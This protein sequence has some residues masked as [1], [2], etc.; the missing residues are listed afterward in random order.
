[1]RAWFD[2]NFKLLWALKLLMFFYAFFAKLSEIY[3]KR[4]FHYW[5]F[6]NIYLKICFWFFWI[7]DT[8]RIKNPF[9]IF[10]NSKC[11]ADYILDFPRRNESEKFYFYFPH[12]RIWKSTS[13]LLVIRQLNWFS[14]TCS[15]I[16]NNNEPS[17]GSRLE[18]SLFP[19]V[20]FELAF[21]MLRGRKA[22]IH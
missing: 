1:M 14:M 5:S 12:S 4:I 3:F 16:T 17:S 2:L 22:F 10:C 8:P 15:C 19:M 9:R 7:I 11:N 18:I 13:H 6:L 20:I 21:E